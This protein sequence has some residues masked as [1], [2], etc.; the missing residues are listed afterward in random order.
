MTTVGFGA[1][2][3][4]H[5]PREQFELV[6]RVEALGFDSVWCGYFLINPIGDPSQERAQLEVIAAEVLPHFGRR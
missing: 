2:L 5:P 3:S 6:R 4:L 1:F